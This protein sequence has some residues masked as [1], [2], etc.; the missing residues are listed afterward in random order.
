MLS[1]AVDG[2]DVGFSDHVVAARDATGEVPIE[3]GNQLNAEFMVMLSAVTSNSPLSS[4]WDFEGI[5]EPTFFLITET[6][7]LEATLELTFA[8]TGPLTKTLRM[9]L[10]APSA[11]NK[12]LSLR[13]APRNVNAVQLVAI[14]DRDEMTNAED[15]GIIHELIFCCV[16][17]T[18]IK[19]TEARFIVN[20]HSSTCL[21]PSVVG[22]RLAACFRVQM[23]QIYTQLTRMS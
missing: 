16:C 1:A 10:I 9:P 11:N 23:R 15:Q 4:Q 22:P 19:L 21:H 18:R 8:N 14:F 3:L 5:M 17:V 2:S 6:Y 13:S 20:S 7:Y 12:K